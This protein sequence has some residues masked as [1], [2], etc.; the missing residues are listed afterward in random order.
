MFVKYWF[1]VDRCYK[2]ML[3]FVSRDLLQG[4][5]VPSVCRPS[6]RV[7]LFVI[8]HPLSPLSGMVLYPNDPRIYLGWV[9]FACLR[10]T[11]K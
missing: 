5:V 10:G 3:R 2:P 8:V 9:P 4:V 7:Y 6:P 11:F 1:L